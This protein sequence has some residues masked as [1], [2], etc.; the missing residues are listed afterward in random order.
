MLI[1]VISDTHRDY[2]NINKIIPIIQNS[3]MVIH[4]GDNID[5]VDQLKK[6]YK[7]KIYNV[8]GNCDYNSFTPS[9]LLIEVENIKLFATHGDKY[10]V[11]YDHLKLLYKAKE[12]GADIALFGH[13]HIPMVEKV[14]DTWLINPGSPSLPRVKCKSIAFIEIKDDVI[15]PYIYYLDK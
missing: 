8:R 12:C 14:E 15:S 2:Y 4:L 13:T 6:G 9:E 11:K 10:G 5:D 7:G 1:A 3:D